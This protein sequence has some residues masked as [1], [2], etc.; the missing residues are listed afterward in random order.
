MSILT[1][2]Y[3]NS[4]NTKCFEMENFQIVYGDLINRNPKLM[5]KLVLN[6][7][8]LSQIM[9]S[10]YSLNSLENARK[11]GRGIS[12]IQLGYKSRVLYSILSVCEYISCMKV[13]N[14]IE[15]I[16]WQLDNVDFIDKKHILIN[17]YQLSRMLG[18]SA[19]TIATWRHNDKTPIS[20]GN[21]NSYSK[22]EIAKWIL[23]N[24][25]LTS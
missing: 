25:I 6:Q 16:V 9:G 12:Y 8:E 20:V 15:W 4:S 13:A 24:S 3:I 11:E 7:N 2:E 17:D 18:T 22:T 1:Q 19:S 5:N 14:P 10:G 23:Q 21:K